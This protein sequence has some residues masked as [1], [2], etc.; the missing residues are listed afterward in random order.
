MTL[1]HDADRMRSQLDALLR[2]GLETF[3][4]APRFVPHVWTTLDAKRWCLGCMAFQWRRDGYW[5]GEA[6]ASCPGTSQFGKIVT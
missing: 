1:R 5:R 4:P 3:R 6:E 2:V